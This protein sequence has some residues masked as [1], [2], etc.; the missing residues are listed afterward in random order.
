MNFL[1]SQLITALIM[2]V[3]PSVAQMAVDALLE[4]VERAISDSNTKTDDAILLPVIRAIR[5]TYKLDQE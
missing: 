3:G 5:D 4:V 1:I 2:H